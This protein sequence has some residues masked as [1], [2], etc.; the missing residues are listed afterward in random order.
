MFVKSS[1][2]FLILIDNKTFYNVRNYYSNPSYDQHLPATELNVF[3]YLS[4]LRFIIF[5]VA[6]AIS[7]D[8]HLFTAKKMENEKKWA[9]PISYWPSGKSPRWR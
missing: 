5:S 1:P 2:V 8:T 3:S 7:T 4:S 6:D 9:L